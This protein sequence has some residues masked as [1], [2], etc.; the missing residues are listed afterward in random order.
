V[1]ILAFGELAREMLGADAP[2]WIARCLDSDPAA[3]P[4]AAELVTLIGR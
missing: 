4:T 3:R 1:D 2:A